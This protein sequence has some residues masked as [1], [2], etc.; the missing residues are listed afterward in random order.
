MAMTSLL[1][2]GLLVVPPVGGEPPHPDSA[3][4]LHLSRPVFSA[5]MFSSP[6]RSERLKL[7]YRAAIA[8]FPAPKIR[9]TDSED[10]VSARSAFQNRKHSTARKIVGAAVGAVG[11]F[12][13]GGYAGA[14][15]EGDS[16]NCDDPGFKG[17]LIGAPIGAVAGGIFGALI[18]K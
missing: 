18:V 9:R 8:S 6:D 1:I 16:C 11:G 3:N 12:F 2:V 4:A 13:L 15:I 5:D 14:A 17:F 7:D 10:Q